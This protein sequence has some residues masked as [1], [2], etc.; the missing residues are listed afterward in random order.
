VNVVRKRALRQAYHSSRGVVPTL[1]RRCVLSR[2][3]GN[4]DAIPRV[5]SRGYKTLSWW[6]PAIFCLSNVTSKCP[7]MTSRHIRTPIVVV[8]LFG[9]GNILLISLCVPIANRL[10]IFW[11]EI[12]MTV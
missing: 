11:E 12:Q 5:G 6:P 3:L 4:D 10:K 9:S 7:A 8:P 2:N 1:V